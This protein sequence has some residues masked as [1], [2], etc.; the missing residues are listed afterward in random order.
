LHEEED[1]DHGGD[2]DDASRGQVLGLVHERAG[3]LGNG[4]GEGIEVLVVDDDEGPEEI[5]PVS[6]E[7]ENGQGGQGGLG[8]G[9]HD[10]PPDGELA[11]PVDPGRLLEVLRD[12]LII[13][14]DEVDAEGAHARGKDDAQEVVVQ[15]DMAA[16]EKERDHEELEGD[17]HGG[18]DE[19]ED[20]LPSGKLDA[21][22]GIGGHGTDEDIH[23]HG[24]G[25]HDH[26]VRKGAV[27]PEGFP[28]FREIFKGGIFRDQSKGIDIA[29]PPEGD[30]EEP[31]KGPHKQHHKKAE[32]DVFPR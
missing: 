28:G 19:E 17:H 4:H 20:Q 16:R 10:P 6:H 1:D 2:G 27:E 7:Y 24:Y 32:N 30:G 29:A 13:L 14:L 25:G 21:S 9:K 5:A 18:E 22:E 12:G 31:E 15:P 8:Q 23:E 3:E 11:G 26:A